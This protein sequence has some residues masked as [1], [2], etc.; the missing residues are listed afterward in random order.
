MHAQKNGRGH[1]T[2]FTIRGLAKP[3]YDVDAPK[4]SKLKREPSS[5]ECGELPRAKLK[6][7]IN[8][9]EREQLPRLE[10]EARERQQ[11]ER[12]RAAALRQRA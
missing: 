5:I 10:R 7:D 3:Q 2:S 1:G 8:S 4:V 6:R 11:R 9:I 12:G